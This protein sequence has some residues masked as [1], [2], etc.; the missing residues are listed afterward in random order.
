MTVADLAP[1]RPFARKLPP[2]VGVSMASLALAVTGGVI[3][4]AQA[5]SRPSVALPMVLEVV[6]VALELVAIVMMVSIRPFAWFR[7]NQVFAV[8][9]V[10][11]V[12]QAGMI[13]WAFA[14]NHTPASPLIAL[15]LGIVVFA[16]IVPVMIAFTVARYQ[17]VAARD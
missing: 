8:A 12:I 15:T 10:A 13:E 16:T 2:V 6:A 1:V 17:A 5:Q 9:L 4:A 14:K 7:F 3:L 11:Y